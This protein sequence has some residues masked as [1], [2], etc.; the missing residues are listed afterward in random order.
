MNSR[1]QFILDWL[2]RTAPKPGTGEVA[3]RT[4]QGGAIWDEAAPLLGL[5]AMQPANEPARPA[6]TAV[7]WDGLPPA[8]STYTGGG[9]HPA[10]QLAKPNA[11]RPP[12]TYAELRADLSHWEKQH[13]FHPH[14]EIILGIFNGVRAEM[15]LPPLVPLVEDVAAEEGHG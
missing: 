13:K 12:K 15:G 1:T 8:K 4:R 10:F 11:E 14:D 2:I 9:F 3:E 5:S 7:G 6:Q